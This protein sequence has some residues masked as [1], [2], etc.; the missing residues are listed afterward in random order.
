MPRPSSDLDAGRAQLLELVEELIRKRGGV[1]VTL[2]ELAAEAGMSPANIYRFFAN[3][4]ALYEAAAGRWFAPKIEIM[5]AVI[6]SEGR[7]RDKLIAFF[8]RRFVLM[9]DNYLAE[10][11]LFEAYLD[12]GD[13]HEEAVRGYIDLGDHYLAMI[14]AQAIDEG[15]FE[16]LSIDQTVSLLNISLGIFI[17]PR[18]IAMLSD[19]LTEEK[20]RQ[21]VDA[22]LIGLNGRETAKTAPRLR[23]V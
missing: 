19:R 8:G 14:V 12:L 3:K 21:L 13:E 16:G 5:E 1:S 20:L 10:P 2:T 17:S 4:E 9:R 22:L 11:A 15:H 6:A 7:A 23:A 18:M